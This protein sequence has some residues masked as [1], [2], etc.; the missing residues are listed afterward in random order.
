MR[1]ALVVL[2]VT[3]LCAAAAWAQYTPNADPLL[4][5]HNFNNEGC[6]ACHA[7]HNAVL[8]G[9]GGFLWARA[10]PLK[11]YTTYGNGTL[12][13]ATTGYLQANSLTGG[14]TLG[15]ADDPSVHSV[16]CLSCHDTVFSGMTLAN[17]AN[18]VVDTTTG[19]N[20]TNN[21]PVHVAYPS[22]AEFWKVTVTSGTVTWTDGTGSVFNY[23]HPAKLYAAA[24]ANSAYVECGS[25][26]NPHQ[27]KDIV[28][29]QNGTKLAVKTDHFV[30]GQYDTLAAKQ[31][32]CVSCHADKSGQ[33][34]GTGNQ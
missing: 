10:V 34:D 4:G 11:S 17:S 29:T 9:E 14:N 16:L 24:G 15:T 5:P 19:T 7:P 22:A 25:C 20:L 1:K 8:Q 2:L 12:S 26:H 27:F 21:H 32:F 3:L 13:S 28:V 30:R 18:A 33:W 6:T 23:G 31:N